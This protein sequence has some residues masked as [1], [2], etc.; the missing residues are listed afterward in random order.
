MVSE[1]YST[2]T[3]IIGEWKK[4]CFEYRRDNKTSGSQT[5]PVHKAVKDNGYFNQKFLRT[6]FIYFNGFVLKVQFMISLQFSK[7]LVYSD[8]V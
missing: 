6:G 8:F 4:K 1:R 2:H 5:R 3:N 7:N